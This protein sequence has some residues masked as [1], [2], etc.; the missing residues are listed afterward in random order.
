[1][2]NFTSIKNDDGQ[3]EMSLLYIFGQKHE[4]RYA[5]YTR[6]NDIVGQV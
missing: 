5:N 2:P 4:I 1:M 3:F 6:L